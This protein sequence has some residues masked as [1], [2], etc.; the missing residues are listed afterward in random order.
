M[1]AQK[2]PATLKVSSKPTDPVDPIRRGSPW[3]LTLRI[4]DG[5]ARAG[6][7]TSDICPTWDAP[8]TASATVTDT[9]D[10]ADLIVEVAFTDTQTATFTRS[11]YAQDLV[12]PD[13][14]CWFRWQPIVLG[15][16]TS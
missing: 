3:T 8:K 16:A 9:V 11:A 14:N 7:W 13:G 4:T 5:A 6:D 12:D 15:R 1:A 2:I 10:G